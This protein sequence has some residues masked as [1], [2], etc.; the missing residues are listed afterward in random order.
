MSLTVVI[1]TYNGARFLTEAMASIAAQTRLPEAVIIVDDCSQDGTLALAH[2]L[3]QTL[4]CPVSI[5]GLMENSGGPSQPIS[6]GVQNAATE[7]VA[8]LDQDDIYNVNC[9]QHATRAL[10][11]NLQATLAFHWAAY[12]D[13]PQRGTC[14][15]PAVRDGLLKLGKQHKEYVEIEGKDLL[16]GLFRWGNFIVGY[17][18]FVFRRSAWLRKGGM[19]MSLKIAGDM[20]LLG[21][22]FRQGSAILVPE[23]GYYRRLH[24]NNATRDKKRR[25]LEIAK[26]KCSLLESMPE[27]NRDAKILQLLVDNSISVA[28]RRRDWITYQYLTDFVRQHR[29][30]NWPSY[31]QKKAPDLYYSFKDRLDK[32]AAVIFRNNRINGN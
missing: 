25:N 12:F 15:R 21:W 5:I 20:E 27:L 24:S 10:E 29:E 4:P 16:E 19:D 18:G 30:S 26:V 8:V 3:S 2:E 11:Q 22:L 14:Q 6:V 23:I 31:P 13:E 17:P 1:P 32:W 28:F 9:L 7:L